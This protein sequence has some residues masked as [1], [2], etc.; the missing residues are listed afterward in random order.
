MDRPPPLRAGWA[1]WP[2]VALLTFAPLPLG[3]ARP[4]A[5]SLLEGWLG[6][7]LMLWAAARIR[8]LDHPPQ[9]SLRPLLGPFLLVAAALLWGWLQTLPLSL[10]RLAPL[11]HPLWTEAAEALGASGAPSIALHPGA[12]REELARYLLDA[13]VFFLALQWG[14]SRRR[15]SRLIAALAL[16]GG[17]YALYGLWVQF[18]GENTILGMPKWAYHDLVTA[19]FVNRN[20]FAA[21]TG[22]IFLCL[23]ALLHRRLFAPLAHATWRETLR[24]LLSGEAA[25]RAWGWWLLASVVLTALLLTQSRGGVLSAGCGVLSFFLL[26]GG[27]GRG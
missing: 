10:P 13:G 6:L 26:T 23:L 19:T 18:S 4:W 5:A 9:R 11:G 12:A 24:R 16:A 27:G 8:P 21:Y 7:C 3:G 2:W 22:L 1:F 25:A 15:S 14:A 20:H 17:G